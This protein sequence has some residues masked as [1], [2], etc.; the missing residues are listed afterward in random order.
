M[1]MRQ[2]SSDPQQDGNTDSKLGQGIAID[3]DTGS[4]MGGADPRRDGYA[5]GW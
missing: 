3:P 4:L 1:K 2:E 5:L